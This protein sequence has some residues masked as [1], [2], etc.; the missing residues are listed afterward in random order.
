MGRNEPTEEKSSIEPRDRK[1]TFLRPTDFVVPYNEENIIR[2]RCPECPIQADSQCA[3]DKLRNSRQ[4]LENAPEGEVPNP[5]NVPGVYCSEGKA[6]CQ[7]L[8]FER[9]CICCI[10]D[11]WKEYDIKD[12]SPNN[13]FC[14]YGR[15]T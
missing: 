2:C 13:H 6:S 3:L 12:A 14:Q 10:C 15:A 5:E 11:V 4:E 7:D 9:E 1:I 8:N